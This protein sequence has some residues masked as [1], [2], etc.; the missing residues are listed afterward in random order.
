M[1]Q[2]QAILALR[3]PQLTA[4]ETDEIKSEHADVTERIA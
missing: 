4:L 2:A 3:L 1:I